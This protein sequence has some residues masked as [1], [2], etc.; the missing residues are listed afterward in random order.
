MK[1]P[2]SSSQFLPTVELNPCSNKEGKRT[3]EQVGGVAAQ[4]LPRLSGASSLPLD[5]QHRKFTVNMPLMPPTPAHPTANEAPGLKAGEK[6]ETESIS[7]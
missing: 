3:S 5:S 6:D 1:A 7:L 2:T 4:H